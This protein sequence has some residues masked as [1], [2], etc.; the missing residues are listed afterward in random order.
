ML[1][2]CADNPEQSMSLDDLA[3]ATNPSYGGFNFHVYSFSDL[4]T[5]KSD[6][7]ARQVVGRK[8]DLHLVSRQDPDKMH[9]DLS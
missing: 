7:A 6:T 2:V 1:G 3:M 9:A 4:F 8:L 5:S